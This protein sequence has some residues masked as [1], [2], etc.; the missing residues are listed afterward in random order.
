MISRSRSGP[1]PPRRAPEERVF[2]RLATS[3]TRDSR[4]AL[5]RLTPLCEARPQGP[6][7]AAG[8]RAEEGLDARAAVRKRP[9]SDPGPA[10]GNAEQTQSQRPKRTIRPQHAGRAA[11]EAA[12]AVRFLLALCGCLA[13]LPRAEPVCPERCDCQHAQHLL[14]TNRGLRAVPKTSSLP[15]P[16]DVLTYS[17]GGNFITNITAFDFHRLGQLRRLDLQYNQIRSLHPKTFE[18]LSRLEELYLGEQPLAGARPGHAGAAAQTA[19]PLRQRQRDR[20]PEPRLLRGL[21]E[22]GEAAAGRERPRGA[23]RRSLRAAGQPALPPPGVQPDPLLGQERLRP[24]GQAALPQPLCQRAAALLAPRGHLRPAA[25][26]LDPHPVGQQPAAPRP[27]RLPTPAPPRAALAQGQPAHA[28]GTGCLLGAAGPARAAPGRQPAEPAALGAA[29][30]PA[31]PGGPGPEWQRAVRAAPGH[32]RP[33]GPAAGAQPARQR[34]QRPLRGHLRCEPGPLPA[35]SGW[36]RL[37]LRLP[38]AGPEALDG[39]LALAGP[40]AHRLRAVSPPAR[41]AGQVPGLLG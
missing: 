11:M 5:R 9:F 22:P 15:S 2:C 35:G 40:A 14:C 21:G 8:Q 19:S 27:P 38:A 41:P 31:Q 28:P 1:P 34:A 39:R 16:Q 33:P 32:L 10:K 23:A 13:L 26:P 30:P 12:L 17:L 36:Q 24:A 4:G 3:S 25:L 20:P 18:K 29:G 7:P 37:D 6:G